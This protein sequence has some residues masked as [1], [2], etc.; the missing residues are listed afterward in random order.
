MDMMGFS[1]AIYN[2]EY[3]TVCHTMTRRDTLIAV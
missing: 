2:I 1:G 3:A